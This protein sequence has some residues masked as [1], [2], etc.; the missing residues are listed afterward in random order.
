MKKL[1]FAALL[2]LVTSL[3]L[4][5]D[6]I[7]NSNTG[8]P[9]KWPEGPI[10]VLIMLGTSQTLSDGSNFSTSAQAAMQIWN[11]QIGGSQFLGQIQPVGPADNGNRVNEMVFASTVFGTAFDSSTL[12]VAT[13]FRRGNERTES[14]VIFNSGRTWDSFRGPTRSGISEIQ[15]VAIH[16]LGHV[17]GL[18]H[19]DEAT[20]VQNVSA[21][22]NSR[23]SSIETLTSDD[24][25]GGQSLYG[26]PGIPAN[27]NFANATT[28]SLTSNP[29]QLSGFN[30]R[31]TKEVGEPNHADNAG[32]HSVWWR[33]TAPSNGNVAIARFGW[34]G[35]VVPA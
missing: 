16:E 13:T 4:G 5:F 23:I 6:Y 35:G 18:D 8:L 26:P 25:A 29:V 7:R 3:A 22:M 21:I 14:D 33:F 19:P 1:F 12:A 11:T 10:T 32:G 27:D 20:P 17:L 30:T 9:L 28:I 31:S 34:S 15:R 2:G 24:I